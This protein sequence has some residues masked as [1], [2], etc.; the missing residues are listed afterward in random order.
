MDAS[1]GAAVP[2]E[3]PV[4]VKYEANEYRRLRW[5]FINEKKAAGA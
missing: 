3:M 5:Q 1:K 4:N 2:A